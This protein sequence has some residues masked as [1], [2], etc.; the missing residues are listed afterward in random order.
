MTRSVRYK[1]ELH[2]APLVTI[3]ILILRQYNKLYRAIISAYKAI[4][5]TSISY[6]EKKPRTYFNNVRDVIRDG[7]VLFDTNLKT[8]RSGHSFLIQPCVGV[9]F[10]VYSF[11][12]KQKQKKKKLFAVLIRV[13]ESM[14]ILSLFLYN[15]HTILTVGVRL[16]E[17]SENNVLYVFYPAR[18]A[19]HDVETIFSLFFP[20][21]HLFL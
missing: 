6:T 2:V 21:Y 13:N 17:I 20:F 1:T 12:V 7:G 8:R 3:N 5:H 10:E 14:R 15:S 19:G 11:T 16:R 18:L 9:L 4:G